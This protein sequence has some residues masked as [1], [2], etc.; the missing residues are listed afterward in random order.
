MTPFENL[1]LLRAFIQIVESHGISA[2]ARTLKMP[3]PTLS[4][5]L[6][7]LEDACGTTLL[8][9]D[10]H[11]MSL[12]EAGDRML[13]DARAML[14]P[15]ED[16]AQRLREEHAGIRGHLR[17]FATIDF[18][19]FT[20]T[21]LISRFLEANPGVTAEL[22]YSNRPLPM[23][24]G[25]YDAGVVAGTIMDES[26]VARPV[27]LVT[28]YLVAAPALVKKQGLAKT[29]M[30][31]R[32]WPWLAL[33]GTQFG[34]AKVVT[35]AK[36]RRVEEMPIAPVFVAEGVTS[37][38]QAVQAGLGVAV[39]PHWLARDEIAAGCLVRVLPG[40]T[41]PEI[42][43]HVIYPNQRRLPARVRAFVEYAA[44]VMSAEFKRTG[45]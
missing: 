15:A 40:W 14:A 5:H 22:G 36:G 32:G 8:R 7:Q 12:T 3:Q 18:G 38:R 41:A 2:A 39:L 6:R 42:P 33:A 25:G 4:R 24:Q 11:R 13:S 45:N 43:I 37:L 9:R 23:I 31:L 21:R 30:A 17:I 26:V 20:V 16:A 44:E 10:T 1:T 35:L 19:Q 27:G 34:G 29:P 28:R